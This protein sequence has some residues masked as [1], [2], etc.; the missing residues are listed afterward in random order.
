MHRLQILHK[1]LNP[2]SLCNVQLND[3]D[4]TIHDGDV[5]VKLCSNGCLVVTLNRAKA[6]NALTFDMYLSLIQAFEFASVDERVECIVL[7]SSSDKVFC[8]GG[9]IKKLSS[10]TQYAQKFSHIEIAFPAMLRRLNKPYICMMQGLVIGGAQSLYAGAKYRI[11]N[12][13]N[14][15]VSLPETRNGLYTLPFVQHTSHISLLMY[16]MLTGIRI[17]AADAL[18]MDIINYMTPSDEKFHQLM[19]ALQCEQSV[20]TSNID[21]IIAKYVTPSN[22]ISSDFSTTI[23]PLVNKTFNL[24]YS[25]HQIIEKLEEYSKNNDHPSFYTDT[26][27]LLTQ[28]CSPTS[29]VITLELMKIQ[30]GINARLSK[31]SGLLPIEL[32]IYRL[33][34]YSMQSNDFKQV[35]HKLLISKDRTT[36]IQW[37]YNSIQHMTEHE[38]NQLI[39]Q[40]FTE[41]LSQEFYNIYIAQ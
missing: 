40:I 1:Q 15:Q 37:S 17:N 29:L 39:D 21:N 8:S 28:Q 3:G 27:N 26:L 20:A 10:D 34:V 16:F 41:P 25:M 24:S 18:Y 11:A 13:S 6:L 32:L 14:F 7:C 4:N 22:S 5:H 23:E 31:Y 38:A 2:P 30:F 12:S 9:D 33:A 19:N 35:V 36:P